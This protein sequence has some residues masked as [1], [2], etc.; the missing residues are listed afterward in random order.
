MKNFTVYLFTMVVFSSVFANEII[1]P[2]P[3]LQSGKPLMQCFSLRRS[4]RN[5][6]SKALPEQII[7]EILFAADGINRPD[8]HKTVPTALNRQNQSVYAVTQDGVYLY[9]SKKHS[10]ITVKQGD[11]RKNC[12]MQPFHA[13]APLILVYVSDMSAVGNTPVEQATF[14]GNHSGSAAQNV[15]LYAASK[16]LS[17]VLCGSINKNLLKQT[18]KLSDKQQAVFS[19][20]IGFPGK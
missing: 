15:Y 12:G 16:G 19:Q 5:F 1:L 3:D 8:G 2:K 17:T 7:S 14:A 9:N 11:F 13:A 18:L 4:S 6:D 20:P 10:L